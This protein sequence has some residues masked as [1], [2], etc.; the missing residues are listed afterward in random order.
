MCMHHDKRDC[1]G[2]SASF[3]DVL[4]KRIEIALYFSWLI[5][6]AA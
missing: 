5:Q 1:F 4:L 2:E 3:L 6:I